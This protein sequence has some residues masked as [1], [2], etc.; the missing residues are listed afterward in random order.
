MSG[1]VP[2]KYQARSAA[3]FVGSILAVS[4][5]LLPHQNLSASPKASDAATSAF[6]KTDRES[7][8]QLIKD[9]LTEGYFD[10]TKLSLVLQ[11]IEAA[12]RSGRYETTDPRTFAQLLTADMQMVTGDTH[13][14][15]NFQPEWYRATLT[16]PS[17]NSISLEN[18][19][20]VKHSRDFHHGLTEMKTLPGNV[21]YL[22]IVGFFWVAGETVNVMDGAMRFL[23][24]GRAIII[25][26]RSNRGGETN[27][28]HY[29][30]SHFFEP[31]K[32]MLTMLST[33]KADVQVRA[34]PYLKS[35]RLKG[36]P[37]YVL[38]N[39]RSRSA[40]EAVAY[41][42]KQFKLGE[43]VGERTEGAA[44]F[45]EDA[46]IAPFYRLSVPS[47]RTEDP[48]SHT[49]WEG[50][51]VAPTIA[52]TSL[53]AL[54]VAYASSLKRLI[55]SATDPE[56]KNFL[57]WAHDGLAAKTTELVPHRAQLSSFTGK[58]GAASIVQREDGLWYITPS[59]AEKKLKP[60][61]KA[62]LFEDEEDDTLRVSIG[63]DAL[64]VLRPIPE[65]NQHFAR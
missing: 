4:L 49:D 12:A 25:D 53:E 59:G 39:K 61:G 17:P 44:H 26:L 64:D 54:D 14:Y 38:V 35:T 63:A 28:A 48:I 7:S 18:A 13:L 47:G 1:S 57:V 24:G 34:S 60:L 15:L 27:A 11:K 3:A 43:V 30:L 22:R 8:L 51:G 23:K 52:S 41:T 62:N 16:P 56:E 29:L 58:Y 46:A 40:A 55:A 19:A 36:I 37:L 50:T 65:L 6:S 45:S 20:D 9:A 5:S 31:D 21:R 32:L 2:R 10:R 42:V 33:G